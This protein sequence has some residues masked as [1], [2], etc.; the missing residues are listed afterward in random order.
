MP[1]QVDFRSKAKP[2]P[3]FKKLNVEAAGVNGFGADPA[4]NLIIVSVTDADGSPMPGLAKDDFTLVN[5]AMTDGHARVVKL[6]AVFELAVE[7]PDARIDGVY[8]VEPEQ[9]PEITRQVGQTAYAVNVTK[10]EA[11]PRSVT[12]FSGQTVVA[13]VMQPRP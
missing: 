6:R 9:E 10:A 7:L 2:R 13:V 1:E 4:P 3:I 11:S 5:Y 8:K 12:Y